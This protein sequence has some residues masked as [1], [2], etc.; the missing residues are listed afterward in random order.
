[1]SSAIIHSFYC[2]LIALLWS[3]S[4][5]NK[6]ADLVIHNAVIYTVDNEFTIA[7]A[8]AID[9]GIIVAIG[10]E[11]EVM[12][13]YAADE[14]I[15]CAGKFVYPGFIDAHCHFLAYGRTLQEVSLDSTESFNQILQRLQNA[16]IPESGWLVA[17]GWDQNDWADPSY[18]A[19]NRLDSLFP[20]T[21]VV[22][23]RIDGHALLVNTKALTL[24]DIND[25]EKIIGGE[26]DL[27]YGLLLDNA[28]NKIWDIM[29]E[30]SKAEDERA[31][32]AAQENCFRVGLTTVS[33][34]GL[35]KKDID[36]IKELQASGKLKMRIYA[37]LADD[38]TNLA[39]YLANGIDTSSHNLTVRAFKFYAD[40]ALGSRGACLLDPY[41]DLLPEKKYGLM[42]SDPEYF[43]RNAYLLKEKGF[44]MCTHAIGD[45]ANRVILNI[46]GEVVGD[47]ADHR[48]RIEHAQVVHEGD[49]HKFAQYHIIPSIQPTHAT[50]DMPWAPARL[51]RNR[52][53]RAY[54][55][56]KLKEQLGMV[57]LG[58]DFPVEGISPLSTFY[59]A[60]FRKRP[61]DI[62]TE[63]FQTE[64]ALSKEDAL[65]GMTIWAAI[66]NFQESDRGSIE[67]GKQAD[68]IILNL[69]IMKTQAQIDLNKTEIRTFIAGQK[70][71]LQNY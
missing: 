10:P 58:T 54:A 31:L 45:S 37:M 9:N 5:K 19:I 52:M 29:P 33:D 35:K 57:A 51:G 24:A 16:E 47:M 61:Q 40:G 56:R 55:Y 34:A 43:R 63:G 18:P 7:Q 50:S 3:C 59:S 25:S 49:L 67:V 2:I 27:R 30:K 26:I 46:Y 48:W 4:F 1:M 71:V 68:F 6:H 23:Q 13:E 64:D 62:A 70:V 53:Y 11:R 17:R 36:L 38:S 32:L 12:N 44:Q 8:M 60:V 39:H 22:L 65:R 28:M 14:Y 20:N 42:L 41:N 15:D 66:A 69:D 21:P